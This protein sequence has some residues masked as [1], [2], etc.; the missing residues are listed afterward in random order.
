VYDIPVN[1]TTSATLGYTSDL[2]H[3]AVITL[4]GKGGT[5]PNTVQHSVVNKILLKDGVTYTALD[6]S[7][8]QLR[9]FKT[10][11]NDRM[12]IEVARG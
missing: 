2:P 6:N 3:G 4:N 1:N 5:A 9:V 7:F 10:A 8:I 11:T 12:L